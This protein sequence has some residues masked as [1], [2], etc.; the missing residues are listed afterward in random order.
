[1]KK[2][3]FLLLISFVFM[4]DWEFSEVEYLIYTKEFLLEAANSLSN[5]HENEVNIN[6]KLKTKIILQEEISISFNE[7]I[8]D[9][10]PFTNDSFINLKYLV[11]IGDETVISPLYILGVPCDDCFSS[12]NVNNPNPK[13]ITG[14]ILAS[15]LVDAN[16]IINN[17]ID[18]SLNAAPG[19]WK[20]KLLLFCDDQY[21]NG[22]LTRSEKW[23]TLHSEV[24][25]NKLKDNLN[26]HCMYG[27]MFERQQSVDWYSQPN[28]TDSLIQ[29][30]NQGVGIINYIGHGKYLNIFRY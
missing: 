29:F 4:N 23:H 20:S 25:Y 7:F 11:I 12:T 30:I 3:I 28:F 14:R 16:I 2:N 18:Y 9:N 17:T 15:N 13:L 5:L 22:E 19:D 1:M 6:D 21:K 26:I 27:P 24:F 8:F 10:F